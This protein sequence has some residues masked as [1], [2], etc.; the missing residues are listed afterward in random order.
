MNQAV[1]LALCAALAACGAA[2]TT[3]TPQAQATAVSTS[4]ASV[5]AQLN[6]IRSRAGLAGVKRSPQL[7]AAAL[8]HAKDMAANNFMAHKGSNGSNPGQR[9]KRAGYRW[10]TVAENVSQGY[11]SDAR[12][13][14]AWRVSPGHYGNMVKRKVT[15]FGMANVNGFRAMVLAAKRC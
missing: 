8:A 15:H 4:G 14:E 1:I 12:A 7:D 10:C 5:Q 6:E 3:G 2:P 13:I 11:R 9:A